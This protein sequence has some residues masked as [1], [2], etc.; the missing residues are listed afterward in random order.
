MRNYWPAQSNS[1]KAED[2]LWNHEYNKHGKDYAHLLQIHDSANYA[3]ATSSQFQQSYF[4]AG[5]DFYKLKSHKLDKLNVSKATGTVNYTSSG[6]PIITKKQL[7][8]IIGIED[9]AFLVSCKDKKDSLVEIQICLRI[10][11]NLDVNYENCKA[12][13][14]NGESPSFD[15][16][17]TCY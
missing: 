11:K 2:W 8:E 3:R 6:D 16:L 1:G 12:I 7:A 14:A 10:Q 15:L 9:E 5:I 4:Q 13:K 17:D